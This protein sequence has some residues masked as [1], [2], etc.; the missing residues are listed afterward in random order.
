MNQLRV[1]D[2]FCG[3]G[4]FSEGFRQEGFKIIMGVDNWLP[5]IVT[6]NLNHNLNDTPRSIL[7]FEDIEKINE[8]PD[9]EI[10][11]GSPPCVSFS[12]SNKGG[13]ADKTLGIRLIETYLR[14]IAVKKHQP[15]SILKAWLMENVPNSRNYV[16]SEYTFKDLDL[17]NWAKKHGFKPNSTAIKVKFNGAILKASDY[18]A[19][20]ARNRFVCGELVHNGAFPLPKTSEK[21][22]TLG[23]IKKSLPA[24]LIR[25][26]QDV[27][28]PN[29]PS[30]L[31]SSV[32][33]TDHF[34]DTGV[35]EIQW[36]SARVA[37]QNHPY[38]GRMSFP[39]NE[40]KPSRT[41]LLL[42]R[43]VR[44]NRFYINLN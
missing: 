22:V 36:Q 41:I 20:Q 31:I 27:R 26:K 24:P 7:D 6:H 44:V 33:V 40:L 28:D 13:N 43:Q 11:V 18:G 38:M 15:N 2:F 35:Y 12:T 25:K 34:Y 9:S 5:A 42:V 39:E 19:A 1:V 8:I 16:K 37:K 29:Y 30:L 3:A 23:D 14:I 17:V 10:I 4:G 32:D 21:I